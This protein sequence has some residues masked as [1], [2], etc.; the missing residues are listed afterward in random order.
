MGLT[1]EQDVRPPRPTGSHLETLCALLDYSREAMLRKIA[2]LSD[3]ELRRAMTPSGVTL[4]GMV[5][6][7]A[8]TERWWFRTTFAGEE[9]DF[10]WADDDPDFDWRI[11]PGETTAAIV[12][13]Y[14]AETARSREIVANATLEDVSRREGTR[15]P[16]GWLLPYMI[17]EVSRHNGHA[18][19]L[20]ELIDGQTGR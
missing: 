1:D 13:L 4:L 15:Y 19:I 8:Y 12:A 3:E 18:D 7:L 2:G 5:K 10:S 16:L 20:R 11:E 14:E 6:H 17:Q 9:H